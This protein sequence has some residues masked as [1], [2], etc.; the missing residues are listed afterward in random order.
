[1]NKV[2]VNISCI[3]LEKGISFKVSYKVYKLV[4][5]RLN[6]N[7]LSLVLP[8][9]HS[10]RDVIGLIITT[11]TGINTIEGECPKVSKKKSLY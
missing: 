6:E 1:M 7:N 10:H 2:S 4:M 11:A 5:D 3:Y 8:Q 9:E